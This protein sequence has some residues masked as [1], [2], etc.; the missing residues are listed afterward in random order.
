MVP[1]NGAP[2]AEQLVASVLCQLRVTAPPGKARSGLA[3]IMTTGFG[4]A[5]I[6]RLCD[7]VPPGPVQVRTKVLVRS[8][9]AALVKLPRAAAVPSYV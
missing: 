7:A 6:V 8:F 4:S 1:V 9:S 3:V 2:L 5:R